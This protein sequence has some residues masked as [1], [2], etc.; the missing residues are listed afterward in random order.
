MA[1]AVSVAA[2]SDHHGQSG[3][4]DRVR[5]GRAGDCAP[6][7]PPAG[8]RVLPVLRAGQVSGRGTDRLS[9]MAEAQREGANGLPS[10]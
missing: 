1:D 5:S 4:C 7:P 3:G 9:R 8:L 10:L 2:S 6:V